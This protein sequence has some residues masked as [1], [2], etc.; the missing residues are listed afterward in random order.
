ML[1]TTENSNTENALTRHPGTGRKPE[2]LDGAR[3]RFAKLLRVRIAETE[4]ALAVL[5][6]ELAS[7]GGN[8]RPTSRRTVS[9]AWCGNAGHTKRT[10]PERGG[11][12][13]KDA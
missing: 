5:R 7:L 2:S 3:S 1:K 13:V 8:D 10:C 11:A 12:A 6:A 4:R 9:C